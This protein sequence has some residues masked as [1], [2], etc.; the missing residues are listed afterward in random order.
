MGISIQQ[1]RA[2]IGQWSDGRPGKIVAV[3]NAIARKRQQGFHMWFRLL[4]LASLLVIG[5]VELNPG[6]ST[7]KVRSR[8]HFD[9]VQIGQEIRN[10]LLHKNFVGEYRGK[11]AADR[12]RRSGKEMTIIKIGMK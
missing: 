8:T 2:T 12:P 11:R 3:A 9:G 6:P 10:H 7:A 4:V 5:C 1:W